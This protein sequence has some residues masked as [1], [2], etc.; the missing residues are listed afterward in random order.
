MDK[1]ICKTVSLVDKLNDGMAIFCLCP[2][3]NNTTFIN[4][5]VTKIIDNNYYNGGIAYNNTVLV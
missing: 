3:M 1:I 4:F 5:P 2:L